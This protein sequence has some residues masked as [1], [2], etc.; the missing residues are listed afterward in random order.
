MLE[1][2]GETIAGHGAVFLSRPPVTR[3]SSLFDVPHSDCGQ[4]KSPVD[5]VFKFFVHEV[6]C[7]VSFREAMR[8]D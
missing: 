1:A 6:V 8:V 2:S 7:G 3:I 5:S 4:S